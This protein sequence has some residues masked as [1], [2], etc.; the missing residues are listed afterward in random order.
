MEALC[1]AG[2]APHKERVRAEWVDYNG[3]MNV[4][5]YMLVFDHASD[6][7]L[8]HI[9]LDQKFRDASKCSVFVVEAHITYE[10]EVMEGAPLSVR[11][12][13]LD[14]DAK[15]IHLFHRMVRDGNDETVATNELMFLYVSMKSRRTALIP[16]EIGMRLGA[17][18]AD[19]KTHPRPVQA[20]RSIKILRKD[21]SLT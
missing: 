14:F 9:G 6:L 17:L 7:F 16:E 11:T 1:D 8:E 3:H 5:Y 20:G 10:K 15:R 13:V 21:I 4:A 18:Y 19:Q 2:L 12:Q